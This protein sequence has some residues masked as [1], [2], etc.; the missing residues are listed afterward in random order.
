MFTKHGYHVRVHTVRTTK[1][2]YIWYDGWWY[3]VV[4]HVYDEAEVPPT[5][6]GDRLSRSATHANEDMISI[7]VVPYCTVSSRPAQAYLLN[8]MSLL[9]C[10]NIFEE[11]VTF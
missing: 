8:T 5:G 6:A 11:I 10:Q 4:V 9:E 3:G 7:L 2:A 1:K